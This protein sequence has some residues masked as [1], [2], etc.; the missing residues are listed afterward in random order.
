MR[1]SSPSLQ[2]RLKNPCVYLATHGPRIFSTDGVDLCRGSDGPRLLCMQV[3]ANRL[4]LALIVVLNGPTLGS[5][6]P[7]SL[8][9]VGLKIVE[10]PVTVGINSTFVGQSL[11]GSMASK[12]LKP[13]AKKRIHK[14]RMCGSVRYL[15]VPHWDFE[16][17]PGKGGAVGFS[18]QL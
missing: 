13:V 15:R 5:L 14:F 7:L 18:H 11:F 6:P 4:Q 10:R 12:M 1:S 3:K 17:M 16:I 9:P 2:L 8:G